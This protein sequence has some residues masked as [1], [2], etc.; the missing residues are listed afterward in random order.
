M[1]SGSE[2]IYRGTNWLSEKIL[3][4]VKSDKSRAANNKDRAKLGSTLG[5][6]AGEVV[7]IIALRGRK[8]CINILGHCT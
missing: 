6:H 3:C 2:Q 7:E 4:H 5:I 8:R 1:D